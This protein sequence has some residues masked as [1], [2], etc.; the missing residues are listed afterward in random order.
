[1]EAQRK[2]TRIMTQSGLNWYREI[3]QLI[4]DGFW[5][6][7]LQGR[8]LEVNEVYCRMSG[9]NV[10]EL[11]AMHISDL[12]ENCVSDETAAHIRKAIDKG[13][14]RFESRHRRKD[15]TFFGIEISLHYRPTDGGRLLAIVRDIADRKRVESALHESEEKFRKC[16]DMVSDGI[17]VIDTITRR[18]L[19]ANAAIC[20]MLG[21][22]REELVNLTIDDI[23]PPIDRAHVL[24][25][26]EKQ[27]KREKAIAENMPVLRK[28]GSI[29]HADIISAPVMIGGAHHHMGIFRDLSEHMREAERLK[30]ARDFLE[31]VLDNLMDSLMVVDTNTY[32]ILHANK[33][34]L[35]FC[36]RNKESAIGKSC[37]ELN[38]HRSTPCSPESCPL[39]ESL[40]TGQQATVEHIHHDGAGMK[41]HL[42]ITTIPIIG[43]NGEMQRAIHLARDITQ[44][45]QTEQMRRQQREELSQVS[46]LATVGE[47]AASIAHE[48]HQPLTAIM[49][50]ALAARRFL[51]SGTA[52]DI[53]EVSDA[54][55]DIIDDD[56]RAADVIQHLRSFLKK[57]ESSQATCDINTVIQEV[58]TILHGELVDKNVRV[59]QALNPDIPPVR[60]GR[61]ELQQILLNLI[62]NSCDSLVHVEPQRRQ[63]V[64]RTSGDGPDSVIVAVEDSGTGLDAN[65]IERC[66]ESYYTTKPDGLGMGLSI[67]KTIVS[68]HGGRIWAEDNP[69]GGAI[70]YFTLSAHKG[71]AS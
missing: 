56:R 58:L 68:A 33:Q 44:R 9:Y 53:A 36:G 70:F 6:A 20:T 22:S 2:Q 48:I 51:S 34:F 37:Y 40:K 25:E 21:Y 5:M 42:A 29:F 24:E 31:T 55:K 57:K 43:E 63:I 30:T 67:I 35:H 69:K 12:E 64:I 61:V 4:M 54:L 3:G 13:K 7:D 23:H 10:Q 27:I 45:K 60:C 8:L 32:S 19:E 71:E 39:A 62:M 26:F 16:F 59:T 17:L 38:H 49:N 14:I 1:M 41:H 66:F 52:A 46:R 28:D 50:N 15:G 18:F 47:F 65:E 11:L